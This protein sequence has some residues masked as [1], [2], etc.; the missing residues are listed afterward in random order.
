MKDLKF[1][2]TGLDVPVTFRVDNISGQGNVVVLETYGLDDRKPSTVDKQLEVGLL[3]FKKID[4]TL[5]DF[6]D[7]ANTNGLT[8]EV[9]ETNGENAKALSVTLTVAAPAQSATTGTTPAFSGTGTPGG[10]IAITIAS[11]TVNTT[12]NASGA[13]SVTFSTL[14]T[15]AKSATVVLTK[16]GKSKSVTRNFTVE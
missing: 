6:I 8:L 3:N 4:Y 1:S 13:W 10:A 14:T 16:D 5:Q 2:G 7:Y 15:G 12:V 9:T 11:T